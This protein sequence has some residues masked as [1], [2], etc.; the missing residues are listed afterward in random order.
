[1]ARPQKSVA[2]VPVVRHH[3]GGAE[4]RVRDQV[5]I[6]EP[7][8]IRVAL[9]TAAGWAPRSIAVT[10]RTPGHDFEL[11][12]GF[13]LT[14][15][16]VTSR[17]DVRELTYCRSGQGEQE[18]NIV[19]VRLRSAEGVDLDRLSRNVYTTSSCG[20]CGKASLEAVEIQGCVPLP[21]EGTV[22]LSAEVVAGL[23]DRLRAAQSDFDRTG[24]LHAAGLVSADGEVWLVHEDVGRHNAVD[25][26]L[27]QS[28]LEGRLP[29]LEHGMV[30]S[31]RASFEILQKAL[32]AG[33]PFV[34]AVGAPSSLAVDLA[35][36]FGMTLAGF[37]RHGGFNV[38]AGA[39]RVSRVEATPPS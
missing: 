33:V 35:T 11:A 32:A 27:G 20:V 12:A 4:E 3:A 37:V 21:L 10:M 17:R 31:G 5:S 38:Y 18:Y 22:R 25:K 19:E 36:R 14:E 29:L 9:P 26:I 1:M 23:P 16:V 28:F 15:G 6:E 13:L 34:A 39:E 7:L 8:E 24:G 30:V 2:R